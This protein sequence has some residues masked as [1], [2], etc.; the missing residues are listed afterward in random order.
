[1]QW[2]DA[3]V[4]YGDANKQGHYL[5][6]RCVLESNFVKISSFSSIFTKMLRADQRMD[7]WTNRRMDGRMEGWME[8]WMDG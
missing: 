6:N 7:R 1:M 8:G 5:T 2:M 3:M 4:T